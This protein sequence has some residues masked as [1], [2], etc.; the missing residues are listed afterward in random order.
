MWTL[1]VRRESRM[2][3]NLAVGAECQSIVVPFTE[4]G[5]TGGGTDGKFN[6]G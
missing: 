3:W 4:L 6:F 5:D 2:S 1:R